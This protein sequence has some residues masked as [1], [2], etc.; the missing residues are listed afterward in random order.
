MQF[1]D[2]EIDHIVPLA[3]DDDELA[4]L[5]AGGVVPADFDLEGFEN[6]LPTSRFQNNRKRADIRNRSAILHFL[7]VAEQFRGAVE[8]YVRASAD[9]G[10]LLSAYL[11][12]KAQ[13]DRNDLAVE[14]IVDIH[15]QE[16]EGMTRLRYTPELKDADAVTHLTAEHARQLMTKPFALGGGH[17]GEVVLQDDED[18]QTVCMDCDSFLRGKDAGLWP[19]TQ[20]DMNCYGMAD[21]ICEML[22]ALQRARYAPASLIR[23]PRVTCRDLDRWS[24]D[25]VRRVWV[26][27]DEAEDGPVFERCRTIGDLVAAGECTVVDATD[28]RFAVVPKRGLA[29]AVSELFRADLDGDGAEEILVFDLSYASHGT[30]RAGAVTIAKPSENGLLEP[31]D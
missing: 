14:D 6:L 26:E 28:W 3:I 17:I 22:R 10:Q 9:D 16:A 19:L 27:F 12:M 31:A 5:R 2:L 21:R 4:R 24:A 1:T 20:F 30:L 29:L 13:A 15:R 18:R 23:Y 25:W 8:G 7:A 11:R